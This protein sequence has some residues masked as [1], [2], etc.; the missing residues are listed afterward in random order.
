M[1]EAV[2]PRGRRIVL[3]LRFGDRGRRQAS[4]G[5]AT[6][7]RLRQ[8]TSTAVALFAPVRSLNGGLGLPTPPARAAARRAALR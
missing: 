4:C 3:R 2:L 5:R 7:L 8:V 6:R 1:E